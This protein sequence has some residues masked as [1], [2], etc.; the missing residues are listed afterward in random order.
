MTESE[1]HERAVGLVEHAERRAELLARREAIE[2]ERQIGGL[3]VGFVREEER[4]LA[5]SRAEVIYAP[6]PRDREQPGPRRGVAAVAR[7]ARQ[8]A[9]EGLLR[10][11]FRGR[12]IAHDREAESVDVGRVTPHEPF[13]RRTHAVRGA[14]R[15]EL[16]GLGRRREHGSGH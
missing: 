9:T 16:L 14:G 13:T 4:A 8:R 1:H 2:R 6:V 5:L 10:E 3:L 12:A 15:F 11:I 7:E